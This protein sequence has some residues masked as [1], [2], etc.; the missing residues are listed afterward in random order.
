MK[1]NFGSW[2]CLFQTFLLHFSTLVGFIWILG[3]FEAQEVICAQGRGASTWGQKVGGKESKSVR[4][5]CPRSWDLSLRLS[6]GRRGKKEVWSLL[7][8]KGEE[9]N[10]RRL[11]E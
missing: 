5:S 3:F 9:N 6:G 1:V 11:G 2:T 7:A 10:V 4:N 8:Y